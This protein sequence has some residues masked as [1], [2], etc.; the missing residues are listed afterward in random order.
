MPPKHV[1]SSASG[2]ETKKQRKSLTIEEKMGVVQ[3]M[4][5]GETIL[6]LRQ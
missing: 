2:Q 5:K 6:P 1:L 3:R 4:E